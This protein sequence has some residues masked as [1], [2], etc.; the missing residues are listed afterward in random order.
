MGAS[1]RPIT[2]LEDIIIITRH[3]ATNVVLAR[4]RQGNWNSFHYP[5]SWPKEGGAEV[6]D[7]WLF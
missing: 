7:L 5:Q 2:N 3:A 4:M 6:G 1:A